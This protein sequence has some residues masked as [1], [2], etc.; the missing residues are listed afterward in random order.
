MGIL[1]ALTIGRNLR[2][3]IKRKQLLGRHLPAPP[4]GIMWPVALAPDP[5]PKLH[6]ALII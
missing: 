6:R 4:H 1:V 3:G 2:L 5:M